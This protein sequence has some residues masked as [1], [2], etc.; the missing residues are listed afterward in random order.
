MQIYSF[1]S[2]KLSEYFQ[3]PSKR[4]QN[5][6]TLTLFLVISFRAGFSSAAYLMVAKLVGLGMAICR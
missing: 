2:K 6:E 5:E 4:I 3:V 1:P